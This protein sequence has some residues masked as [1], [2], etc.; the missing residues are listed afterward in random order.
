M[1]QD[2]FHWL[3]VERIAEELAD[4]HPEIDP[5]SI[6]FPR[7]RDLVKSLPGFQ[8]QPDHPCNERILE[9]IQQA[10]IDEREA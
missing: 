4:H 3:D 2:T 9:A 1:P 6:S 8:P 5:L 10:W 7:L